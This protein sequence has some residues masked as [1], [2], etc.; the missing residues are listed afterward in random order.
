MLEM[1]I[2]QIIHLSE[3][4]LPENVTSVALALGED[5][6]LAIASVVAPKGGGDEDELEADSEE[7]E[8][9]G[10]EAAEEGDDSE[11]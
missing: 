1:I 9:E 5:H 11:E 7:G 2:G 6:D 8:G 10:E 4:A 3:I